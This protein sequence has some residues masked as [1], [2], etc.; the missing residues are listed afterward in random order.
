MA[1]NTSNHSS[2]SWVAS[3]FCI[4]GFPKSTQSGLSRA[5]LLSGKRKMAATDIR[6]KPH[7]IPCLLH[8][9][10]TQCVYLLIERFS[11]PLILREAH[12]WVP[13]P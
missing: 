12:A 4:S 10:V 1:V 6:A 2:L 9:T 13:L 5:H 11:K 3:I 7:I 8:M